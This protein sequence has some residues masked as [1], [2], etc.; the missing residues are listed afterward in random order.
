[1]KQ[2]IISIVLMTLA[3]QSCMSQTLK[4]YSGVYEGTR[5]V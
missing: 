2:I 4:T 1:M 5:T 3:V